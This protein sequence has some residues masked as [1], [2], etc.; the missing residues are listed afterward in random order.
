MSERPAARDDVIRDEHHEDAPADLRIA[1]SEPVV[2][3]GRGAKGG[4]GG[5]WGYGWFSDCLKGTP[6]SVSLEQRG[7][8]VVGK[9]EARCNPER[10][11][12]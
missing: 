3:Q 5:S 4:D 12:V 1:A 2:D 11:G 10:H 9:G 8:A 7:S 6:R